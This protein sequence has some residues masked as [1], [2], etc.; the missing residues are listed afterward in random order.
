MGGRLL[1]GFISIPCTV[2]LYETAP[3]IRL[4][5]LSGSQD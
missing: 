3:K 1:T 4:Q 2:I 5:L